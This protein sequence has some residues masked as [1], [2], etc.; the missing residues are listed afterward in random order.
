MLTLFPPSALYGNAPVSQL[1]LVQSIQSILSNL[2]EIGHSIPM[3][4][5]VDFKGVDVK[6]TRTGA[7]L[8]LM[9]FQVCRDSIPSLHTSS[10]IAQ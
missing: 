2:Y 10:L 7:S 3:E 4:Y 6:V 1:E 9:L 5:T 8:Y